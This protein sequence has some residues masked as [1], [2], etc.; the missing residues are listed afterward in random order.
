MRLHIQEVSD[1]ISTGN[2]TVSSRSM[3]KSAIQDYLD[4]LLEKEK[5]ESVKVGN[6]LG[7]RTSFVRGRMV[8][9]VRQTDGGI[10]E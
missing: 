2:Y 4:T 3:D 5:E 7:T 9:P 6:A 8:R 10:C 1:F